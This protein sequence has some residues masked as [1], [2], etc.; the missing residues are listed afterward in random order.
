MIES[1]K[2]N[3]DQFIF[4]QQSSDDQQLLNSS[5]LIIAVLGKVFL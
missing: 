3:F 2:T 4:Q 1:I 5:V